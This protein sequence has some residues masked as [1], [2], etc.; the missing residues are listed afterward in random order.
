M[1]QWSAEIV[2]DRM[3]EAARTLRVAPAAGRGPAGLRTAWPDAPHNAA[4][5][6]GYT[7][8]TAGWAKPT[9][10]ALTALDAVLGWVARYLSRERCQAAGIAPDAGWVA[11]MRASGWSLPKIADHR[12]R[13]WRPEPPPKGNSRESL[14]HIARSGFELVANGLN[15]DRVPLHVGDADAIEDRPTVRDEAPASAMPRQMDTRRRVLN[16]R[17]C[18]ECLHIQREAVEWWRCGRGFGNVSPLQAA[19]APAD[20]PCFEPIDDSFIPQSKR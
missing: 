16:A 4:E 15:R 20:D 17:P 7:A 5:A 8:A 14:R 18:G 12:A 13:R 19:H 11:W 1:T 3:S 10:A 2:A 9:P 6:Y